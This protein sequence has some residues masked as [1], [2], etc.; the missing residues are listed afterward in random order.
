MRMPTSFVTGWLPV[1]PLTQP[2]MMVENR[3][4][5]AAGVHDAGC[6]RGGTSAAARRG[7]HSGSALG[8][9]AG[10]ADDVRARR[11]AVSSCSSLAQLRLRPSRLARTPDRARGRRRGW[12]RSR[13]AASD[14][15]PSAGTRPTTGQRLRVARLAG[16][17]CRAA[18][19]R[20]T[21]SPCSTLGA[22]PRSTCNGSHGEPSSSSG[23]QNESLPGL[24]C[25][26]RS[27][28]PGRPPPTLRITS[29]SARPMVEFARLP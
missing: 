7:A 14:V 16:R 6:R 20:G 10:A 19:R 9:A 15:A 24:P 2:P 3:P 23:K 11:A 13:R 27:T 8:D 21:A 26:A 25:V 22:K 4:G 1:A 29:C 5:A 12:R 17:R 28:P 18:L